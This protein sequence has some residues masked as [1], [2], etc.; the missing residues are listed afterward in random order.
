MKPYEELVEFMASLS[1][2][3]VVEFKPSENARQRVWD[4][5][6]RQKS[7]SLPSDEKA[8]LDHY[9]EIEHLTP[10]ARQLGDQRSP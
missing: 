7:A 9:V 1:P 3:E 6:E 10:R 5:I 8:E 2:R 4:L